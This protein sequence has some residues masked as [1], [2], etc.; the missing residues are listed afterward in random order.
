MP[1]AVDGKNHFAALTQNHDGLIS[2]E[3]VRVLP[4][5]TMVR[6]WILFSA[7]LV[8]GGWILSALHQLNR[9]GYGMLIALAGMAAI[10]WRLKKHLCFF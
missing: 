8:G 3:S 9:I 1:E 5:L 2:I 10:I 6:I 7:L 4:M